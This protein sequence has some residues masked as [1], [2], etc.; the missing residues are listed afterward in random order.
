MI[1]DSNE[2]LVPCVSLPKPRAG[3]RPR[4][5]VVTVSI[6][7]A[8]TASV[9]A[10]AE[11]LQAGVF[12]L[13][14]V[15]T[16]LV[17]TRYC[18][19]DRLALDVVFAGQR[20]TQRVEFDAKA[21]ASAASWVDVLVA[22]RGGRRPTTVH[23]ASDAESPVVW[24]SSVGA[25]RVTVVEG[26]VVDGLA[27]DVAELRFEVVSK[28]DDITLTCRYHAQHV[29][30]RYAEA[31]VRQIAAV[32]EE[33]AVRQEHPLSHGSVVDAST[34]ARLIDEQQAGSF[35]LP[36]EVSMASLF[37]QQVQQRPE[38]WAVWCRGQRWSYAELDRRSDR[39]VAELVAAGVR[40][41]DMVGVCL[42]RGLDLVTVL[43]ALIKLGAAYVPLDLALPSSRLT[44]MADDAE[45]ELVV[46]DRSTEARLGGL[47]SRRVI[48]EDGRL[49]G[50]KSA[51]VAAPTRTAVH[52]SAV[53]YVNYTSGS[54]GRPKGV[55]VLHRNVARLV[56]GDN[57][58][59]LGP[60]TV[61][62]HHATISFDAATFEI[63]GA[64]LR[65]G[66][67][68]VFDAAFPTLTR[69]GRCIRDSAA[70]T[71]FLTAALFNTIIDDDPQLLSGVSQVLVGGEALSPRHVRTALDVLPAT[72]LINGYGP[73]ESTTF[74]MYSLI[75]D[76]PDEAITV[77]VGR[78]LANTHGYVLDRR[79][80]LS[81]LGAVGE[82]WLGGDGL[83]A[84][85]LNRPELTAQRFVQGIEFLDDPNQRLYRTGDMARLLPD[86]AFDV[87]GRIDA[88]IKLHGFRIELGEIEAAL[89]RD[90]VVLRAVVV[91]HVDAAVG[92]KLVAYV[93]ATAG[94]DEQAVVERLSRALPAY[95]VPGTFVPVTVWPRTTNGKINRQRLATA[96]VAV[97]ADGH[98]P[99][100]AAPASTESCEANA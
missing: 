44:W 49:A 14:V 55:A 21:H 42:P 85:Y 33:F 43:V 83:A 7:R 4:V 5:G 27:L 15:S 99:P 97:D 50:V 41:G 68:A 16:A 91:V 57:C 2:E 48:I 20:Q 65:G 32:L 25:T 54:T 62:L 73:T 56:M 79:C 82:L 30:D 100:C 72:R 92:K 78:S 77:P 39:L 81:P 64:L 88:Q 51:D 12:E 28:P 29:A 38:R 90:P 67:C 22:V 60:S 52:G 84:G 76:V 34:T 13:A 31:M 80:Q 37:A 40:L 45:L 87:L 74:A 46:C 89:T 86:G 93:E 53:A 58:V 95:M 1:D 19:Q 9:Q 17:I 8:A 3:T 18:D 71:M 96:G 24:P 35:A 10:V 70:N 94:W 98:A 6:D 75:R 59:H 26:D 61:T 23:P 63:W 66:M 36:D 47:A 69:L 11:A